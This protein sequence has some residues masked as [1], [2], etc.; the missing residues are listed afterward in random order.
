[1]YKK[2]KGTQNL[3]PY[4]YLIYRFEMPLLLILGKKRFLYAELG[5]IRN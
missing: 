1:M 2:R 4:T 3:Q 5:G